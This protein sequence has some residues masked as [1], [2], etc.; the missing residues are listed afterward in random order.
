[1]RLHRD[2]TDQ[3]PAAG[4]GGARSAHEELACSAGI[5]GLVVAAVVLTATALLRE[6]LE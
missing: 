6:F 2:A 5:V 3:V 4:K 1:M